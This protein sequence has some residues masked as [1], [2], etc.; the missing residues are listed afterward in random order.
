MIEEKPI[1]EDKKALPEENTE[2]S[3]KIKRFIEKT[4]ATKIQRFIKK[5]RPKITA[6]YLQNICS[7]SG[8]CISFGREIKKINNFFNNFAS[9]DYTKKSINLINSGENG[10]IQEVS[11]EREGYTANAIIKSAK[12]KTGDNLIYEYLVENFL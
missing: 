5:N 7:K 2:Q 11:Y 9:F 10:F 8:V 1:E 3:E 12:N 6:N 4:Q